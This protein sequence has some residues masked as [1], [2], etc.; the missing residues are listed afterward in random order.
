VEEDGKSYDVVFVGGTSIN[1]GV[2]LLANTRHP[3]IA[4]D[5]ARTFDVLKHLPVEV[6]LAQHPQMYGMAEKRQRL[7]AGALQNPFIDPQGYQRFVEEQENLYLN[8]LEEEKS[9][10]QGR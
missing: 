8:Q 6:F 7:E 1:P 5:Y 9:G 4:E 2:N 3:G 10:K